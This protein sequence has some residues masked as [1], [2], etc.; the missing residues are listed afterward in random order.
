M[1]Y[2]RITGQLYDYD[3][4]QKRYGSPGKTLG[5]FL[6]ETTNGVLELDT[7]WDDVR[8][9]SL[10]PFADANHDHFLVFTFVESRED[11]PFD[12][13]NERDRDATVL[14]EF[15]LPTDRPEREITPWNNYDPE[16][17]FPEYRLPPGA[18][19]ITL[20]DTEPS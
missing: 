17:A 5:G 9:V 19:M 8:P 4:K 15:E 3:W 6:A 7:P 20:K 11:K 10:A 16:A 12:E 18:K 1:K 13:D 2:G 14:A